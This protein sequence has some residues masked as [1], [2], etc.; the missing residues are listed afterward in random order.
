[1]DDNR[2]TQSAKRCPSPQALLPAYGKEMRVTTTANE[3]VP[4]DDSLV[5]F[6][7]SSDSRPYSSWDA[8]ARIRSTMC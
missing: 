8:W 4:K 7:R 6:I 5:E 2:F 3:Q 1:M